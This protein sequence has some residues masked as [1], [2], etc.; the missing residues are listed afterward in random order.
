MPITTQCPGC[1]TTY[2]VKDEM[3]GKSVKCKKCQTTFVIGA[4]NPPVNQ[5]RSQR[6]AQPS[7]IAPGARP[8]R[9]PIQAQVEED[10]IVAEEERPRRRPGRIQ[11][12]PRSNMA[13]VGIC[14]GICFFLCGGP[15]LVWTWL[16]DSAARALRNPFGNININVPGGGNID[17][18]VPKDFPNIPG[19]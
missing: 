4:R 7:P 3:K 17:I 14:C 1:S 6:P 15:I 10:A 12:V 11:F 8:P 19:F 16:A 5:G 13:L 2:N 18:K 9:Q